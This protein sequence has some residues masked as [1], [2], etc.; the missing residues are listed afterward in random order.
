M[1]NRISN[2]EPLEDPHG[3]DAM[4]GPMAVRDLPGVSVF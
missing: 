3:G 1:K 2:Q 4:G